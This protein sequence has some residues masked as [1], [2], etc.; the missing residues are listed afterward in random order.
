MYEA[1]IFLQI[2]LLI[3]PKEEIAISLMG[4]IM[5]IQDFTFLHININI[6]LQYNIEKTQTPENVHAYHTNIIQL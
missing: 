1:L 2:G 4:H 6:Y 3:Q 5:G